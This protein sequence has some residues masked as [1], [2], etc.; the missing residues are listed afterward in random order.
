[1]NT[2]E[3]RPTDRPAADV[4]PLRVMAPAR[5]K[6]LTELTADIQRAHGQVVSA[7]AAGAAHAIEAGEALLAA[8][9]LLR[10]QGGHGC[11]L[12]FI[13]LE[14]RLGVRTAQI[15]MYLFRN[16]EKLSQLLAAKA[17]ANSHLTQ[18]QALKLL[19]TAKKKRPAKKKPK[20]TSAA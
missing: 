13:S 9:A 7:L 10:E 20:R 11:W 8:K 1:V 2:P 4:Q 19:G 5:V 16:K 15:Y 12:D 17:N 6:N 3:Q 18:H 14:C